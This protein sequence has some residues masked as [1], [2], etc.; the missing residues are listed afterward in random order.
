MSIPLVRTPDGF[1]YVRNAIANILATE[2]VTQVAAAEAWNAANP[3]EERLNPDEWAFDVFSERTNSF[4]LFRDDEDDFS[5]MVNVWYENSFIDRGK[6]TQTRQ[7]TTTT[8]NVDCIASGISE[9]TDA[10]HDCGDEAAT[11]NAQRVARIC[12]R[13]LMHP[14]YKLLGLSS[15][16][17]TRTMTART[18]SPKN[19]E[20]TP[21]RHT[22]GVQLQFEITHLEY[23]DYEE[24]SA[25]EG[26][27]VTIYREPDGSIIAQ[28]DYDWT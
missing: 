21:A 11:L 15:F 17:G 25:S 1:E 14:D 22:D 4:E 9:E 16:V 13:I 19:N 8:V 20:Q 3:T 23:Y 2:T 7:W 26:A 10:G 6:S 18:M 5:Q 24:L 27:L 28:M 12:R